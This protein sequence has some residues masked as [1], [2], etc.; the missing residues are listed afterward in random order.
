MCLLA[1]RIY[2]A[3]GFLKLNLSLV[4]K[5]LRI[6]LDNALLSKGGYAKG[7]GRGQEVNTALGGRSTG[8]N[9]GKPNS[10]LTMKL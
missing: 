4:Q 1:Y 2:E 8:M 3:L 5:V 9:Q 10:S 6:Y 7:Q